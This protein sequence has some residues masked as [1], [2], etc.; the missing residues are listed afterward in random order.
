MRQLKLF[1]LSVLAVVAVGVVTV[2][3]A[4]AALPSVL[5]ALSK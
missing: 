2:S 4:S 3:S 5:E 1:C